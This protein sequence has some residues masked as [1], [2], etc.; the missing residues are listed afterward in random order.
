MLLGILCFMAAL[1]RDPNALT[2]VQSHADLTPCNTSPASR[3]G[4]SPSLP[5]QDALL[6]LSHFT[7]RQV[8]LSLQSSSLTGCGV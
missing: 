2:Q 6:T 7:R 8:S 1:P 3:G 4:R 5:A